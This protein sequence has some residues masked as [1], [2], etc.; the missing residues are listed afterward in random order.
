[1]SGDRVLCTMVGIKTSAQ[2]VDAKKP[3]PQETWSVTPIDGKSG[4]VKTAGG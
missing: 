4:I 1:M 3:R 2:N